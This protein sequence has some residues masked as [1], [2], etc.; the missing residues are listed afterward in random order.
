M[1][2]FS[3]LNP[4][5]AQLSGKVCKA[6]MSREYGFV[7]ITLSLRTEIFSRGLDPLPMLDNS[8]SAE[9]RSAA[10]KKE[11][12]MLIRAR[13]T[14]SKQRLLRLRAALSSGRR[15]SLTCCPVATLLTLRSRL[16]GTAR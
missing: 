13:F 16:G 1:E 5:A 15:P 9:R 8:A 14:W 4:N 2:K 3:D 12:D 7:S 10:C 11:A 6:H